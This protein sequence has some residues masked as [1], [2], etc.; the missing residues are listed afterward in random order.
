MT[1]TT[2]TLALAALL[3]AGL[4]ASAQ[5]LTVPMQA[6]NNQRYVIVACK[7]EGIDRDLRCMID[8]GA[9]MTLVSN[10]LLKADGGGGTGATMVTT[11]GDAS[12]STKRVV[13]SIGGQKFGGACVL[14]ALDPR[15]ELLFDAVVG[16]DVLQ[17][18]GTVTFDFKNRTVI[19]TRKI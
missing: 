13:Y 17:L 7:I 12:V 10:K 15:M 3:L 14:T 2:R 6:Q 4:P 8:S 16:Q 18:F 9:A 1:T 5:T 11:N 19:L